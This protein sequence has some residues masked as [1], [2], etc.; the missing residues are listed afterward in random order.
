MACF[1]GQ[2][3][4][5]FYSNVSIQ[6]LYDSFNLTMYNIIWTSLPIFLFGLLEQNLQSDT[7]LSQPALYRRIGMST[8]FPSASSE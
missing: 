1:G 4:Y 3:F 6:T 5:Q 7:L 2:L 8:K